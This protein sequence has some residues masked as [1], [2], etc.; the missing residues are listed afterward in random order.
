[1]YNKIVNAF[2][3]ILVFT[4]IVFEE[5][6]WQRFAKPLM[7]FFSSL[8]LFVRLTPKILA[9][10]SYIIL[11]SFITIFII[12]E[13]IGIY[14]GILFVSGNMINAIVVYLLKIPIAAFI[15]WFFN[16]TKSR[17]L[18]F[19]WFNFIYKYMLLCIEM[20]KNS[21]VYK[22][23]NERIIAFREFIDKKIFLN[24]SDL[25]KK[26]IIFY[27]FIKRKVKF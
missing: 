26:L 1:M 22:S 21:F 5:L 14:A 8:E 12:V 4:Y 9:L 3:F 20:I 16:I 2:L 10:N 25:K 13:L 23:L 7:K 27:K 19:R 6:I 17:L 11:I 24:K 18:E 15:F